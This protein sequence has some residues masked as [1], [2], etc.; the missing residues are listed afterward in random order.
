[1]VGNRDIGRSTPWWPGSGG[2]TSRR[3]DFGGVRVGRWSPDPSGRL[4]ARFYG[5]RREGRLQFSDT[6]GGTIELEARVVRWP[7][8]GPRRLSFHRRL[9]GYNGITGEL[10]LDDGTL[11][12]VQVRGPLLQEIDTAEES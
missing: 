5:W 1:V 6:N 8:R 10:T 9:T 12:H 4:A 11:V 7:W 3:R 2:P